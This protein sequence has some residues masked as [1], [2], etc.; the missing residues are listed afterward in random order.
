MRL[1]VFAC[2]AALLPASAHASVSPRTIAETGP[3]RFRLGMT[4]AEVEAAI[5]QAPDIG[6]INPSGIEDHALAGFPCDHLHPERNRATYDENRHRQV[7]GRYWFAIGRVGADVYMSPVP[8]GGVVQRIDW[9]E[10]RGIGRWEQYLAEAE[11][12]LG[13]ADVVSRDSNGTP[14]AYWCLPGEAKCGEWAAEGPQITLTYYAYHAYGSGDA[15]DGDSLAWMIHEG[16]AAEPA[17]YA[18]FAARVANDPLG[19]RALDK[20]CRHPTGYRDDHDGVRAH[21]LTLLPFAEPRHPATMDADE[22]PMGVFR[23][24]GY[25]AAKVRRITGCFESGDIVFDKWTATCSRIGFRWAAPSGDLWIVSLRFGGN[26]LYAKYF[27]VRRSGDGWRKVWWGEELA[28]FSAWRA[29]GAV[30][31]VEEPE[32]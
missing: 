28:D 2:V 31:M 16:E 5:A 11:A 26:S 29:N 9:S 23:A 22:V 32:N 21:L 10:P 14:S 6:E 19:G 27:A 15:V 1:A 30:P 4:V 12:R 24:L 25:D 20:A 3:G 8:G 13:K 7:I 18:A 17:R